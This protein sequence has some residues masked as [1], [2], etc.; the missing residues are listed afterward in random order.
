MISSMETV[1]SVFDADPDGV[2]RVPILIKGKLHLPPSIS[3]DQLRAAADRDALNS[4]LR[5]PPARQGFLLNDV[6]VLRRP[7]LDRTSLT[8][9]GEDQF[10]LLPHPNPYSLIETDIGEVTR[11]L[12]DL[13][14]E[15]IMDFL[16][17][18]RVQLSHQS[19]LSRRL[20]SW[21]KA[22]STLDDRV[23]DIMLFDVLPQLLDTDLIAE[24]VDR[25]LGNAD[26]GGAHYLDGWVP[27]GGDWHRGSMALMADRIFPTKDRA[28][29][30]PRPR[31]RAM[32][33]RQLHITAGNASIVPLI[34]TLRAFATKGAAVVKSPAESIVPSSILGL[35]MHEVDPSHPLTRHTSLVYWKGGDRRIEDVLF[36]PGAFDRLVVWGS[37]QTMESVAPRVSSTKT[38]FLNPRYGLSMIGH[39][40]FSGQLRDAAI[41][42]AADSLIANQAACTASLVHYVEGTEQEALDYC[43]VLRDVLAEWDRVL[44]HRPS[45]AVL[46]KL[47]HLRRAEFLQGTWFENGR[48]PDTAS[49]VVFM[50]RAFDLAVHPM[51]RCIL[52]RQVDDLRHALSF[53]HPGVS[54]IGIYPEAR[55]EEL[56]NDLAARG[57]SNILPLGEC[58]R[59]YAGMPHDGMRILSELVSWTNA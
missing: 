8:P 7:I 12:F 17:A 52:V 54:T 53:V 36:A 51:S 33:T 58:E 18:L 35:A 48:W 39:E 20:A 37:P 49:V 11:T 6:F 57:V 13:P 9:T 55:R 25:E 14:F 59:A 19:A 23:L 4:N 5:P 1:E 28:G 3:I 44:P 21:A 34:S 50:P 24:M 41:R 16:K 40:A 15:E 2:C 22:T 45:R 29:P 43:Q 32:P 27:I 10:V 31:I 42:A 56:R 30:D 38:I 26:A 47:R 46:G